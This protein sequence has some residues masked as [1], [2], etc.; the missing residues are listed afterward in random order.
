M[1]WPFKKK[2]RSSRSVKV[3]AG[4][5]VQFTGR[6][7][8]IPE[9]GFLGCYSKSPNEDF[10]LAWR[11]ADPDG[12]RG[13][14]RDSGEGD[15]YL[16][17][18]E[19]VIAEGRMERP[20]QGF[21]ANNGNFILSDWR[22]GQGLSSTFYAFNRNG[23]QLLRREFDANSLNSGISQDGRFAVYM[24]AGGKT[25][26][27]SKIFLFDL[28]DG[29]TLWS[30]WPETGRP[31]SYEF[32]P[33]ESIIWLVYRKKGRYAYSM[34]DGD[35][36]DWERWETERI[37]WA[38]AWE[39]SRIGQERLKGA[40]E[41][42]LLEEGAEIAFI[43]KKAIATGISDFPSEHVKVLK[44]LGDLWEKLGDDAEALKCLE[45]AQDVYEK[46]GVKRKIAVIRK[47]IICK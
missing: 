11:D 9:I 43:L 34:T 40:E 27:A 47:R 10:L 21:V 30:K 36:M 13:G 7:A 22:F 20:N 25:Q 28:E 19:Q 23:V 42:L 41:P 26:D 16:V 33:A 39:L 15:Y 18:N 6:M 14:C 29:E 45:E 38:S 46:A 3:D 35:F 37:D 17:Q 1:I 32:D 24:T 12:R 31:D 8:R 5:R 44:A 2:D 4:V